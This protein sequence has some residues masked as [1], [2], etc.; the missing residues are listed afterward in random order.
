M[1][2]AT[3]IILAVISLANQQLDKPYNYASAGPNSF[4][5]SGLVYYC[6]LEAAEIELP[7]TAKE[8]GYDETYEKIESIDNL[9]MGDIV[10]FNTNGGDSDLSD[11]VGIYLGDHEFIHA[12]SSQGKVIISPLNE[13]YYNETFS[14]ARRIN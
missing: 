4:D 2:T 7:R 8:I 1:K 13:G 3:A 6:F 12:S 10:C 5:C 11:H 9:E 14:W